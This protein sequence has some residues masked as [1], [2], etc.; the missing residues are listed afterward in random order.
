MF[1][2]KSDGFLYWFHMKWKAKHRIT[3][4]FVFFPIDIIFL[5]SERKIIEVTEHLRPWSHYAPQHS[6]IEF[7]EVPAGYVKK[8]NIL[9][10]DTLLLDEKNTSVLLKK[11]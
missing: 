6:F 8:H 7:V 2:K 1:R 5:D 10:G 11:R 4:W 9:I 3:M